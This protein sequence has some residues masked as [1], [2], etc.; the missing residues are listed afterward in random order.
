MK[1]NENSYAIKIQLVP[2]L[3]LGNERICPPLAGGRGVD[4]NV[5][6]L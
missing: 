2:K 4:W 1:E 6:P 5:S 3:E